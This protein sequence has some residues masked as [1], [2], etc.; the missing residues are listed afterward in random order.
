[1]GHLLGQPVRRKESPIVFAL[2]GDRKA[3]VQT[4]EMARMGSLQRLTI[5]SRREAVDVRAPPCV[6]R[7]EQPHAKPVAV[8][9]HRQNVPRGSLPAR[10]AP[11]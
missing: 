7:V 2:P 10:A 4:A 8:V 9:P 3:S 5:V 1:M 6:Q 11:T